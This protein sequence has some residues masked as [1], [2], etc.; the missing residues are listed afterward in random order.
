MRIVLDTN[1]LVSGIFFAGLPSRILC[2]W[3]EGSISLV[4]SPAIFDEYRAVIKRLGRKY[5]PMETRSILDLIAVEAEFV[6]APRLK[7]PICDDPHDDKFFACAV[8]AGSLTI[9]SGDHHLLDRNGALGL[10]VL[11]PSRFIARYFR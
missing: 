5:P 9:V 6:Q 1:V 7:A 2:H 8:A 11:T 4:V 10:E 3:R